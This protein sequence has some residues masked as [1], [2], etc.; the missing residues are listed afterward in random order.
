LLT[1][2]LWTNFNFGSSDSKIEKY[3]DFEF[4]IKGR[5]RAAFGIPY[6]EI[7]RNDLDKRIY[8]KEWDPNVVKSAQGI[9]IQ[10]KDGYFGYD[11]IINKQVIN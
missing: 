2:F 5:K 10:A 8:F 11:I 9:F 1:L 6:F 7:K 4:G 3:V